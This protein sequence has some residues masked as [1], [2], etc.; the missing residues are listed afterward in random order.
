MNNASE[1]LNQEEEDPTDFVYIDDSPDYEENLP[2]LSS[3]KVE[4]VSQKQDAD[5]KDKDGVSEENSSTFVDTLPVNEEENDLDPHL[6]NYE[7]DT[8]TLEEDEITVETKN[9]N[10]VPNANSYLDDDEE[11]LA[12]DDVVVAEKDTLSL[13]KQSENIISYEILNY[14]DDKDKPRKR[15]SLR[16][17]PPILHISSSDG[18]S[19]DFVITSNFARSMSE[20]LKNIDRSYSGL[21]SSK[22]KTLDQEEI[23]GNWD[24]FTKWVKDNK[25]KAGVLIGLI[26]I[27]VVYT[28]II[29]F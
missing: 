12:G 10:S 3:E 17:D 23:R 28:I 16:S 26:T 11:F 27:F 9:D 15:M 8:E 18:Q 19:V 13:F 4:E 14:L 6:S 7:Y 20:T 25:V 24:K 22:K 5:S 21:S 1:N 2:K 29:S